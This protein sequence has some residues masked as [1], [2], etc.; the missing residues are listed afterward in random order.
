MVESKAVDADKALELKVVD[1]IAKDL[2]DLL[3]Q[4]DGREVNGKP[5]K[6]AGASVVDIP[7]TLQ[8]KVLQLLSHPE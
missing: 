6:T 8:E 2:P 3:S 4:L 5:L 1:L 7:M